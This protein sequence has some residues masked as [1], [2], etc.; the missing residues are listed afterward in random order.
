MK[1]KIIAV[2]KIKKK[3]FK[4]GIQEYAQRLRPYCDL[5]IIEVPDEKAPESLSTAQMEQVKKI[6]GERILQK[7]SPEDYVFTLEIL[8]K[9]LTSEVFAAKIADLL[10]YGH[11][12]IVFVIG[13][14][15][16][17]SPQVS[18][19]SNQAISFGRFTLPHQLMRLVLSE[20]I[21]RA[22]MINAGTAYHK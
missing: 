15:L 9:E 2:G 8:G 14:S 19:R 16:G 1:I 18:Q 3:F 4:Q 13:G 10:T 12:K 17:L 21:Y 5:K 6:E 11:S 7:I 22:F 20:Q